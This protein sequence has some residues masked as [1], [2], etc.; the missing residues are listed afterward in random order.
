VMVRSDRHGADRSKPVM[1]LTNFNPLLY[2][3]AYH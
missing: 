1:T 2:K 3:I